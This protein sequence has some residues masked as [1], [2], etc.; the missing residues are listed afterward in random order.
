MRNRYKVTGSWGHD[1]QI[2]SFVVQAADIMDM[3]N[4]QRYLEGAFRVVRV[5]DG[6]PAKVG[7]GGTVPFYGESAWS[8]AERLAR[9]LAFAE[10]YAG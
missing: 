7:K 6:K 10:R 9:D 1:K 5:S 8:D 4:G 3:Q 2:G